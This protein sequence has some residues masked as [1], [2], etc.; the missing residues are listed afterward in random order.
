MLDINK[1]DYEQHTTNMPE[2][3]MGLVFL[4]SEQ[5][6]ECLVLKEILKELAV[7]MPTRK[8]MQS[9]ATKVV[10]NYRDEDTPALLL[11]KDNKMINQIAGQKA[12]DIFG[13]LRMN[14]HTVTYVLA[15]ELGF[16]EVNFE[17]DPRDSLKTFNAYIHKKKKFLG[18]DE[19]LSGSEGEDDREYM[20]N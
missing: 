5:V 8:F 15:K 4:Y 18:Q 19:D 13:G 17:E 10:E 7:K 1:Q 9:V 14:I 16:L 20:N 6:K 3:T 11:Y 2:G 12:R